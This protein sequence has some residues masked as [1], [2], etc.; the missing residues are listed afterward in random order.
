MPSERDL[1]RM[2]AGG[3]FPMYEPPQRSR[4]LLD[5]TMLQGQQRADA[6]LRSGDFWA[7]TLS[8]IGQGVG[9]A[10]EQRSAAKAKKTRDDAYLA[11]MQD[12]KSLEDPRYAHQQFLKA[13]GPDD[14]MR[15]FQAFA[16]GLQLLQPNRDPEKDQ[17]AAAHAIDGLRRIKDPQ[18][19]AQ[20][21]SALS[22]PAAKVFGDHIP[23]EYDDKVFNE[24][25]VPFAESQI[26][27]A[28][29]TTKVV[30]GVLVDDQTGDAIYTAPKEEKA[31][32]RSLDVQAADALARGDQETYTRLLKVK[33]EMGQA[34][35]RP[36]ITVNTGSGLSA[37]SESNI[38]NRLS[39]QWT[40][41]VAPVAEMYRQSK[42][43][44]AGLEAA[45][46]GDLASGSQAVLVTFQKILDPTSVVRES[47][48]ARSA[49]GQ[50]LFAR[51]EGAYDKLTKGGAGVP[52]SELEKFAKLADEMVQASLSGR[53][54]AIKKRIGATAD[55]YK[56]PHE[57]IFE[58]FDFGAGA[59]MAGASS[60]G[61]A[62]PS[63]KA[64]YEKLPSGT[65]YVAPDGSMRIKP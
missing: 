40:K 63:S 47:E 5:L 19:R 12:P 56:I 1:Y 58:D 11:I 15:M 37:T 46:R 28:Q 38:I 52:V 21:W 22:A 7:N 10:L 26:P 65:P 6:A 24:V 57:T 53:V 41:A 13:G 4:S 3:E 43:M 14:G 49:E 33:K 59:P 45:R 35:D 42:L 8:N 34:D 16:G 48:Y 32:T 60:G 23:K 17:K 30:N 51:I 31:E 61:P 62:R 39:N 64:D 9:Q 2:Y 29:R 20:V 25:L 54:G 27:K 44:K 18:K 36:R 55:R 50:A